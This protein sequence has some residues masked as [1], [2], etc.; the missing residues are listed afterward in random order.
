MVIWPKHIAYWIPNATDT[1]TDY[2][3]LIVNN[4]N[5]LLTYSLQGAESFLRS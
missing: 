5:Y 2:V 3:I 1:H 4:L